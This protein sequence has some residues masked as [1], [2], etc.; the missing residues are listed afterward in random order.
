M[1]F[2]TKSPMNSAER[3]FFMSVSVSCDVCVFR[4]PHCCIDAA[5]LLCIP[6]TDTWYLIHQMTQYYDSWKVAPTSNFR[7]CRAS[8]VRASR[9]QL[10]KRDKSRRERRDIGRPQV[11]LDE[12]RLRLRAVPARR[13]GCWLYHHHYTCSTF[14][15]VCHDVPE[16]PSPAST[17]LSTRYNL[18]LFFVFIPQKHS[19]TYTLL[20]VISPSSWICGPDFFFE[21]SNLVES[22]FLLDCNMD[23]YLAC[24]HNCFA[25]YLRTGHTFHVSTTTIH[26]LVLN[27]YEGHRSYGRSSL[28]R[29]DFFFSWFLFLLLVLFS[30][31]HRI[32]MSLCYT[33]SSMLTWRCIVY[34][35]YWY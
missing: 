8:R 22:L 6:D 12:P 35:Y 3:T 13:V 7:K 2:L 33:I 4:V 9:S 11:L 30:P 15:S 14:V 24:E 18:F 17:T 1:L 28:L 20:H 27:T 5:V 29:F 10:P 31:F 25:K 16:Y 19:R 26:A 32:C 21:A 23:V 34:R